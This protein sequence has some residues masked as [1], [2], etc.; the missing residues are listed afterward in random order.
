MKFNFSKILGYTTLFLG[1]AQGIY[2]I[3]NNPGQ[4]DVVPVD[5][6]DPVKGSPKAPETVPGP[7]TAQKT[8]AS[9]RLSQ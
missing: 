9:D 2:M 5:G 8:I 6:K 1:V 7:P 3:K 4:L